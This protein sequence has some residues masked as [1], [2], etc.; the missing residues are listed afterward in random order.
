MRTGTLPC[1][2]EDDKDTG[3]GSVNPLGSSVCPAMSI[4]SGV[5]VMVNPGRELR[6][7]HSGRRDKPEQVKNDA[8]TY[9]V[10]DDQA[11]WT[12]VV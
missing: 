8:N 10:Q 11:G 3:H 2:R 4:N 1:W 6:E 9:K 7:S 5:A 12:L